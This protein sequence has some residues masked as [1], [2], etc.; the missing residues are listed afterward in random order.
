MPMPTKLFDRRRLVSLLLAPLLWGCGDDPARPYLEYAGGGFVFNYRT[1]NHFYGFVVRQAKP[2]PDG[3]RL[4]VI[5]EVPGGKTE[6]QEEPAVPG[7]L[8][9]KFQ[10]GDLEG[11]VPGHPY[12]ATLLV[13]DGPTGQELGRLTHSFKTDADQSKLPGRPLVTGPGYEPAPE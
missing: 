7:R 12:V 4:K 8:Q 10:T 11:I 1:A 5:F 6:T 3:A 2:L 13:L 9:Y